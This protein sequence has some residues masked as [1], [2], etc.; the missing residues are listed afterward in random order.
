VNIWAGVDVGG[1]RRKRLHLAALT[2]EGEV[3][4]AG[5]LGIAQTV[6][7]LR[8]RGPA[9]V[10]VDSPCETARAGQTRRDDEAA[11]S[12]AR[13]CG[14]RPTPDLR[15]V[16]S[17]PYYEWI[18]HGLRL[19]RALD[20][21]GLPAIECFPTAS[22]TRWAGSRDGRTRARWT[23]EAL[24]KLPVALPAHRL[25]QDWRD[26]IAAAVTAKQHEAGQTQSFGRLV[27]P[28]AL[29]PA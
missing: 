10:A 19:Y 8:S 22:F 29:P 4:L 21:A 27:V 18:D 6:D 15:A 12:R 7:W 1:S 11:F 28:R 13:I 16:R 2:E 23:R 9:L 24:E 5:G 14:I 3:S 20:K 26:A 17:N 25:N